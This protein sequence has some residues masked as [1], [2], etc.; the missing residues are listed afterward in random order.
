MAELKKVKMVNPNVSTVFYYNSVLDFPQ[1]TSALYNNVV[2]C[3]GCC[4]CRF[5]VCFVCDVVEYA[6]ISRGRPHRVTNVC[7]VCAMDTW[8]MPNV[9]QPIHPHPTPFTLHDV[10]VDQL[11]ARM[12]EDPS[13]TLHDKNGKQVTMSGGGHQCDVFDFGNSKT[14]QLFIETCYNA[15]LTGYVDGCFVDRAVDGTPTD[16]GNDTIPSASKYNLSNQT[17]QAYF[18]GHVKVLTDLQTAIGEGPVIA[19]HAYG[20]PHDALKAGYV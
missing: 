5:G 20:P 10:H 14:R 19:N 17:A 16:S 6:H 4:V 9:N 13:L 1:C 15:T 8:L 18:D 3:C 12:L 11:H 7:V 2:S